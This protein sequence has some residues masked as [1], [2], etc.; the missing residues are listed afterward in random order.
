[1]RRSRRTASVTLSALAVA[2]GLAACG[3]SPS[4]N[5]SA[6]S[7]GTS[8]Q[9]AVR[10]LT[11]FA[12]CMRTHGIP[13]PDPNSQGQISGTQQL[14]QQY[15]NTPQGQAALQACR[16]YLQKAVRQLSPANAQQARHSALL[17]ARCM[18][19]HGVQIPDPGPDGQINFGSAGISKSSP[20]FQQGARA[21]LPLVHAG[22]QIAI[23][24]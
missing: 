23:G 24:G 10:A 6:A 22:H 7:Q 21:C 18:R 11:Q 4:A 2:G 14:E 12:G 3:G 19:A 16:S 20:Q 1:M 13:V 5:T 9:Q 15:Q 17:F 8:Q